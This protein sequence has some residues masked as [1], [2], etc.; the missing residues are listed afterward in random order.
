MMATLKTIRTVDVNASPTPGLLILR[1]HCKK[2][3][4]RRP[5]DG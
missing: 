2:G 5:L 1:P 4:S 3:F